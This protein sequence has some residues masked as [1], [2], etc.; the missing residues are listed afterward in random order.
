LKPQAEGKIRQIILSA[1]QFL[2]IAAGLIFLNGSIFI[3]SLF[4]VTNGA[5]AECTLFQLLIMGSLVME[6]FPK[7]LRRAETKGKY[8]SLLLIS[9]AK[10]DRFLLRISRFSGDAPCKCKILLA[11]FEEERKRHLLWQAFQLS[12]QFK[13]LRKTSEFHFYNHS[14]NFLIF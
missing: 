11:D 3:I 5:A 4:I 6:K 9:P 10:R 1:L 8:G 7:L 12:C 14:G 2:F 13:L